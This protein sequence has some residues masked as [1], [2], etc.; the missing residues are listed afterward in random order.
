MTRITYMG[1]PVRDSRGRFARFPWIRIILVLCALAWG[2]GYI[3]QR[4]V[5]NELYVAPEAVQAVQEAFVA[6]ADETMESKVERMKDEI[7]EEIAKCESGGVKEP[8]ATILL[9]SNNQMSIGSWQ[10]QIKSVQ[11]YIKKFEGRDITRVE[12]I[13][14]A[15]DHEKAQALATRVMF[16]EKDG[17]LNWYN[18]A[19][20]TNAQTKIQVLLDLLQ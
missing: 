16:E 17:V 6:H 3:G 20:K 2:V 7:V 4:W 1:Q 15:V 11:H 19:K 18:C 10:W 12:A 14:I 5:E 9:D 13:Q 8:D